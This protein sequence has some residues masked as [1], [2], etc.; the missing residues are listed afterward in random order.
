MFSKR[1]WLAFLAIPWLFVLLMS[2]TI[3]R[4]QVTY[5]TK[6]VGN[7]YS[8]PSTYVGNAMRSGKHQH[9]SE[10]PRNRAP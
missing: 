3:S 2:A 7:T 5:T 8:T 6:W 9:L 4:A 10:R 1:D